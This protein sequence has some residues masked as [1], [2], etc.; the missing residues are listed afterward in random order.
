MVA[1]VFGHVGDGNFHV[2]M[3]LHEDDPPEYREVQLRINE[4]MIEQAIAVGGT[5]TGEHGVGVGKLSKLVQEHGQGAVDVM[6]QINTVLDPLGIMN[7]GKLG[8]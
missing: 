5:C 8:S 7:P 4:R 2:I 1:P 6:R 3:L